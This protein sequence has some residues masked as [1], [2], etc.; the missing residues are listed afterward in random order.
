MRSAQVARLEYRWH[1]PLREPTVL[2]GHAGPH[3]KQGRHGH[4]NAI[5]GR[6]GAS[7]ARPQGGDYLA[8]GTRRTV[9]GSFPRPPF[10]IPAKFPPTRE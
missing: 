5:R 9:L 8:V 2:Q 10:V 3:P 4:E 6:V 1:E 7:I